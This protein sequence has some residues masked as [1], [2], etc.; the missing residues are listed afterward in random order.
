MSVALRPRLLRGTP[1]ARGLAQA[2]GGSA[3]AAGVRRTAQERHAA[4]RSVLEAP[5]A[6]GFLE[7][8]RAF[9]ER[10][11][12]PEWAELQGVCEGF[13]LDPRVIL[14]LFHLSPLSGV[15][16]DDGCSA[17]AVPSAETG[18][19]LAKNRDLSG[20]HR[21]WQE[22]FLH[23]DPEARGGAVFCVG[24]L[25]APGVYSSGM[26]EAGL[27]LA[28]TAIQAPVHGVGWP[29]YFL[30][31]RLLATCRSVAEACETVAALRHSGGG[32]L[33]LADAA[34]DVAVVELLHDGA[35]IDRG[36]PAFRSNH[37]WCEDPAV[38]R[39]R[40]PAASL[41]STLG[42][43]ETMARSLGRSESAPDIEDAIRA[44][45]DHGGEGREA[46]CR[47]G[48]EDGAHTVSAVAYR[49][50]D[51]SVAFTRGA[52]CSTPVEIGSIARMLREA[53]S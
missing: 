48:G 47:H 51:R 4:A 50:A 19:T 8:Q 52:P 35:R 27:A 49:T 12:A 17:F 25:G 11:C 6:I 9:V 41:R 5:R 42:R 39:A 16:E 28:D 53:A 29:R 40:L 32:S 18:A 15:I 23:L 46:L 10:E 14:A 44:L 3:E 20:P 34:G 33:V 37:F 43:R 31:T 38:V 45:A 36:P 21:N 30:M 24:T 26:N 7:R 13:G 22:T 2:A 1:R